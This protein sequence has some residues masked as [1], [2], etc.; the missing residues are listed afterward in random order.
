MLLLAMRR[1]CARGLARGH[2]GDL[3]RKALDGALEDAYVLRVDGGA[4][5]HPLL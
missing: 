1:A 2:H 5:A 4:F 3:S